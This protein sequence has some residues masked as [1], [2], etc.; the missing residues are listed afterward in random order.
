MIIICIE[1]KILFLSLVRQESAEKTQ[2]MLQR[3]HYQSLINFI[4][5]RWAY[6]AKSVLDSTEQAFDSSIY[7]SISL[8]SGI[9]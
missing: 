1:Y 2:E 5:V 9:C 3:W 4:F 6:Q 7:H 8:L